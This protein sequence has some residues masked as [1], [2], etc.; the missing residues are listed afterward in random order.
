MKLQRPGASIFVPDGRAVDDALRRVTHLG[1]G[2]HQDDLEVMA[3][4]GIAA[5]FDDPERWFGGI[6]CTDGSASP[7]TGPYAGYS[8]EEMQ[9]VRRREQDQ[10]AELGGYGAM[11]Q[12]D[13]ASAAVKGAGRED[14]EADLV[15]L[16]EATT[17]E[18]VYTHN[19]ADKHDTHVA[20]C[21]AVINAIRR[22]PPEARPA[23][24]FG[25]ETWRDLDWLLDDDVVV[26]DVSARPELAQ[27]LIAVFD[28]Q[29]AGGKRYDVATIGRRRSNATFRESH[30]VDE[31]E[32]A[33][34][35]MD[36][37]PL[38]CDDS[39]DIGTY[40]DC[41][42]ERFGSDVRARLGR[43]GGTKNDG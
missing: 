11:V 17:P 3:Y 4:H 16:L 30:A 38:V 7:R 39:L 12:L 40:V 22:L 36:L 19:P 25:C 32:Q 24:V 35:A 27:Q 5:C 33:W 13:Y 43:H 21:V 26:L 29:I 37:G 20:V 31:L 18:I 23:S 1:I 15:A 8:N 9:Q 28:S 2:A 10:A 6:T 42:L 41:L 34:L 14:F